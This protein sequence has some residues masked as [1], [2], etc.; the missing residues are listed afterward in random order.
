MIPLSI[1]SGI[2]II[3]SALVFPE[4]VNAQY[5]KR[6]ISVFTPLAKALRTQPGLLKKSPLD[7]EFDPK[8]FINL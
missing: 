8:P 4:S 5:T 1:H 6:L 7:E 2:S 3:C